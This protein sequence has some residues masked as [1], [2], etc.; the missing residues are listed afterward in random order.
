[1]RFMWLVEEL[2]MNLVSGPCLTTHF[3][4]TLGVKHFSLLHSTSHRGIRQFLE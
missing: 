1:M 3:V 2:E 4:V